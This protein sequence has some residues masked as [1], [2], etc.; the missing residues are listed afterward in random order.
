MERP[1]QRRGPA[2]GGLGPGF[3]QRGRPR[4]VVEWVGGV[5]TV[6]SGR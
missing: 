3:P 2:G 5:R 6:A 4:V 1:A